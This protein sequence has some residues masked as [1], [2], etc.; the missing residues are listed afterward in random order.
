MLY[1]LLYKL[2]CVSADKDE[3]DA[4][5]LLRRFAQSS[6]SAAA[7]TE[8]ES[9]RLL[10]RQDSTRTS[11][12]V[13]AAAMSPRAPGDEGELEHAI[14]RIRALAAEQKSGA[15]E[16]TEETRLKLQLAYAQMP[17]A[18]AK[19]LE[20]SLLHPPHEFS[21]PI[22]YSMLADPVTC[23]DGKTYERTAIEEHFARTGSGGTTSPLTREL[24]EVDD[25]SGALLVTPNTSLRDAITTW[26]SERH[27]PALEIP[28]KSVLSA[29]ALERKAAAAQDKGLAMLN[30]ERYV[31]AT[32]LLRE[33]LI[34]R[35]EA[36]EGKVF[37]A[38]LLSLHL[39]AH[40]L[41]QQDKLEETMPL[42]R[43]ALRGYEELF[44]ENHA[45]TL[46]HVRMLARV[47]V[48]RGELS[49]AELLYRR[50]WV[51]L[52]N[53]RGPEDAQTLA[54][55]F[56]VAV[57]L[58]DQGNRQL[59][60]PGTKLD[61]SLVLCE[62]IVQAYGALLNPEEG[63]DS[64]VSRHVSMRYQMEI[65]IVRDLQRSVLMKKESERTPFCSRKVLTLFL[66]LTVFTLGL[67]AL[68]AYSSGEVSAL[69]VHAFYARHN[70]SKRKWWIDELI[71]KHSKTKGGLKRLLFE[72]KAKYE[73]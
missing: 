15:V 52:H 29:A 61:E 39:L 28:S 41:E 7:A 21:C 22:L 60:G 8:D 55:M 69:K 68:M 16:M 32:P 72:L 44:G 27:L 49:E 31:E 11:G 70:P 58:R 24:L 43:R 63:G 38:T 66:V 64:F 10:V 67:Y 46:N 71:K 2:G 4:G 59:C 9:P 35:E 54:A 18:E 19:A 36:A 12:A 14:D 62:Q 56:S 33:A 37:E 17:L 65:R 5:A 23:S 53:S 1:R 45:D 34:L 57:V 3:E 47:L 48:T 42:Y 26:R 40:A 51:A 6:I 73:L 50:L 13:A 25:A 30:R 20:D